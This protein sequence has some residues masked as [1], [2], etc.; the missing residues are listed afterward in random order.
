MR[1]YRSDFLGIHDM[2]KDH[3]LLNIHKIH[4]MRFVF[5]LYSYVEKHLKLYIPRTHMTLV[6]IGKGLVFSGVDLRK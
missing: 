6:L 1:R 4:V 3:M 5:M 2:Q